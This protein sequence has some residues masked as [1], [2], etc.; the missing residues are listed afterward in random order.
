[1]E[2]TVVSKPESKSPESPA[3]VDTAA[4]PDSDVSSLSHTSG[5]TGDAPKTEP[6]TR[7]NPDLC[8]VDDGTGHYADGRVVPGTLICSAHEMHYFRDGTRRG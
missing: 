2:S 1:M 8:V 3:V 6:K 5:L 4:K 7:A